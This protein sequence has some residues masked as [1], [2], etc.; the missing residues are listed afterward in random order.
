[1]K[2]PTT[3]IAC[4]LVLV[5]TGC[6]KTVLEFPENG[7]VDPTLVNAN[8]TLAIDPKIEPYEPT[9]RS[10]ASEADLH[11][12]RWAASRRRTDTIRSAPRWRC[13]PPDTTSWHGWTM[14]TTVRRPTNTTM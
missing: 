13:M 9:E 14:W 4:L 5:S 11:D 12:V 7:G 10:K 3:Y 1:M 6:D 8:L 2:K